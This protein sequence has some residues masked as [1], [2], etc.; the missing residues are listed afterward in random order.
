MKR[1]VV[2]LAIICALIT[3]CTDETSPDNTDVYAK[4]SSVSYVCVGME[5]SARFGKCSGCKYDSD[6]MNK[7][8]RNTFNYNGVLLQ[9]E[10]A[11]RS[12]VVSAIQSA[13]EKTPSTGLFIFYYSG[14]GG[15][16]FLNSPS[17]AEPEGA[18]SAD[19][20]LCLYDTYLLDDEVWSLI[21]KCKGRVFLVFDCCHSQTMFRSVVSDIMLQQGL[22]IPLEEHI[23][24]SCGFN[25]KP[26]AIALGT[27][28]ALKMLCWSG[29]TEEEYSYGSNSG[30]VMTNSL[31]SRWK[32]GIT[33][34]D[35]WKY[36]VSDVSTIHS[37]QHPVATQYGGNF[38][39]AFK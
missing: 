12:A 1:F 4:T 13:V 26:V 37:T 24:K 10:Q 3:G 16:E 20:Y 11:T 34:A 28:D 6:R 23:V 36:I 19:E 25:L 35:L 9:S 22:A 30:G 21:S 17:T 18:D 31:L 32:A 27:E 14:H 7:L 39:E 33:Y 15:R 38:G 8:L 29:C 5:K 2:V